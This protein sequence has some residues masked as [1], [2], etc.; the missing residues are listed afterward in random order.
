MK[1]TALCILFFTALTSGMIGQELHF[2]PDIVFGNRSF[3]YKHL[4]RYTIHPRLSVDNLTLF[5][6]EYEDDANNIYF[7]RNNVSFVLSESIR[8]NSAIGIKNPGAF[9]TLSLSYH[10]KSHDFSLTYSAGSTYQ[11]GFSFEQ[12]LLIGYSPNLGNDLFGYLHLLATGNISREGYTRGLQQFKLGVQKKQLAI[13][14]AVNLDQFNNAR[15]KLEN[16]GL[17]FTYNF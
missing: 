14:W 6:T 17:F 16:T 4:I 15:K 9:G 11:N 3:T 5:D 2:V 7:I 13:G 8:A 10:F 1:K 12:S